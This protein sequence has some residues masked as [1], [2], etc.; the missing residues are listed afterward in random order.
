MSAV[1]YNWVETCNCL[2]QTQT[3]AHGV[4]QLRNGPRRKTN[5]LKELNLVPVRTRRE[6]KT[7]TRIRTRT[8]ITRMRTCRTASV[9]AHHTG[10]N[11]STSAVV[12]GSSR[13][14]MTLG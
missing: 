2:L 10:F 11:R 1:S 3:G 5:I 6:M 14:G 4:P 7:G 12:L 9:W 13:G 8:E